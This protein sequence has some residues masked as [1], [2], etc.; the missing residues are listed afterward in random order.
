MS[1]VN[2]QRDVSSIFDPEVGVKM[3]L[4]NIRE[5]GSNYKALYLRKEYF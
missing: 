4:R 2:N 3:S 1:E 5:L